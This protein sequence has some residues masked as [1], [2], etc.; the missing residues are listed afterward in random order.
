MSVYIPANIRGPIYAIYA[1]LGL[2]LGATQ[3]GFASAQAG[4]P[5]WLTVA[6]SVF[7][8]VGVG[9]GYTAASNTPAAPSAALDP[10]QPPL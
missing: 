9:I 2:G 4:Q 5:T 7:A 10:E 6:L 1:L 8:F 3:V